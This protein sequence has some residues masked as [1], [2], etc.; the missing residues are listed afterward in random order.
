MADSHWSSTAIVRV[1][2][3]RSGSGEA[4][5]LNPHV[6][7]YQRLLA[8][9]EDE[10]GEIVEQYL[11]ANSV[12]KTCEELLLGALLMLKRDMAAGPIT[13]E[14]GEFVTSALHEIIDELHGSHPPERPSPACAPSLLIGFP[15]RDKVDEIAMELLR[16]ML[17][18]RNCELEVLSADR[19]IGERIAEI[20]TR[21][22]A[23]VCIP[24]LPPGDIALTR[25]V[26]KRLR[27]RLPELKLVVGRL[28]ASD[29][30][31]RTRQS[32]RAAGA[33][34]VVGTLEALCDALTTVVHG[35]RPR[36]ARIEPDLGTAQLA[37]E[38]DDR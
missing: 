20:A 16:V 7:L 23:A 31:E 34:Q 6:R 35:S 21:A 15:A 28:G 1:A 8:R 38:S 37:I 18:D 11:K 36:A 27:A 2:R 19:L 17:R 12:T 33:R 22:P 9:D 26:C 3:S 5:A 32:L 24:S 14:D 29:A 4:P 25:N 13:A 30:T 10:A